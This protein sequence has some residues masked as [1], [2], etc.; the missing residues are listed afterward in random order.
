[1]E[2]QLVTNQTSRL[3][4][5][6]K[7]VFPQVV[8]LRHERVRPVLSHMFT[9]SYAI[10]MC[11][12]LEYG[13]VKETK[14]MLWLPGCGRMLRQ[15]STDFHCP[16]CLEKGPWEST[17]PGSYL[18][19]SPACPHERDFLRTHPFSC[20]FFFSFQ[21]KKVVTIFA[22]STFPTASSWGPWQHVGFYISSY[23]FSDSC[24]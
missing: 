15:S 6:C 18:C 11:L 16:L 20:W 12:K 9:V 4:T 14:K 2:S 22:V 24:G 3:E 13:P 19:R 1:M 17:A 21:E 23:I 7:A 8:A 5:I 10:S